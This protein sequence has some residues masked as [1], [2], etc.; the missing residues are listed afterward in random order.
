MVKINKQKTA[1]A[2]SEKKSASAAGASGT[3]FANG[4]KVGGSK[5]KSD[6]PKSEKK[7]ARSYAFT[8]RI[9]FSAGLCL[10]QKFTDEEIIKKVV[11]KYPDYP[12]IF[13]QKEV[14][15]CRWMLKHDML[16]NVHADG[17]CFDRVFLIDGKIVPKAD[18]PKSAHAKRKARY[19][20]ETDPLNLV[21][22]VNVHK[23]KSDQKAKKPVKK[24][25]ETAAPT[26]ESAPTA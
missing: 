25:K 14:G 22:G 5:P 9:E 11:E 24:A 18:R 3:K 19:N 21:A 16:P 10:Q 8:T 12:V 26:S 6:K 13:N 1:S 7:A 4:K 20:A 23:Q 15:R 17:C 2:A